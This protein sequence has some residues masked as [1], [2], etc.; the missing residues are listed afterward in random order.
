MTELRRAADELTA[1]QG[2]GDVLLVAGR[3]AAQLGPQG[4]AT[5]IV[6]FEEVVRIGGTGSAPPAAELAWAELLLRQG[7]LEAAINH[8]ESVI[9]AYPESAVVPEARR[10]L[11][12]AKGAIPKS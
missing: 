8:L 6:L 5:A 1:E 2:R 10:R 11:D 7:H 3:I 9:L 4:E 12:A